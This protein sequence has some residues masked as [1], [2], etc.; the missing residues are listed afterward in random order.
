MKA[1]R[2]TTP[3]SSRGKS[4][5]QKP[6]PRRK[7]A[8]LKLAE[9]KR[10]LKKGQPAQ[11]RIENILER[12]SD[13]FV[14]FD[15]DMNYTYVNARGGEL[16]EE[17]IKRITPFS[18]TPQLDAQVL[19]AHIINKPRTWVMAHPEYNVTNKEQVQLDHALNKLESELLIKRSGYKNN[20][21]WIKV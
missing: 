6:K 19:L 4:I 11:L 1:D 10:V 16:L 5:T 14:A 7:P 18:D 15:A 20:I 13:G 2:K 21:F 8:K 17:S 3:K 9:T 12:V